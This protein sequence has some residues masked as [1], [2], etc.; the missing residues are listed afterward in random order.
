MLDRW[1]RLWFGFDEPVSRGTYFR[2][3]VALT[4]FKYAL[5][6]LLIWRFAGAR[7]TPLDYLNPLWST[8][9][10]LLESGPSWLLPVL[11]AIALPFLWIGVS[12]SMRRAIDAGRSPWIALLFFVPVI[13]FVLMAVLSLLPPLSKLKWPVEPPPLAMDDR[14]KSAMLGVAASL[15]ITLLTVGVGV[16]LRRSYSTGLF[17]GAPFTIG[18]ISSYIYNHGHARPAGQSILLALGSVTIAAGALVIFAL[19]GLICIAMA[20]PMTRSGCMRRVAITTRARTRAN[21]RPK[22]RAIWIVAT[23]WSR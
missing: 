9:Q 8:R 2:H 1:L 14:M 22:C 12:M 17:L 13:N 3:G 19:E 4:A 6:A 18:Y 23:T 21:S 20:W 10:H 11:V 7:W 15:A 16:Y 5:D